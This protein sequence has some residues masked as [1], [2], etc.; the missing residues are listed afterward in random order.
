MPWSSKSERIQ[1]KL[2]MNNYSSVEE[3][4]PPV[5]SKSRDTRNCVV[6]QHGVVVWLNECG[7]WYTADCPYLVRCDV[8]YWKPLIGEHV[9]YSKAPYTSELFY[10]HAC[11]IFVFDDCQQRQQFKYL[12]HLLNGYGIPQGFGIATMLTHSDKE[13]TH[14]SDNEEHWQIIESDIYKLKELHLRGFKVAFPASGLGTTTSNMADHA[15]I[16][17]ARMN[18][19]LKDLFDY[20]PQS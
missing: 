1:V 13:T 19:L 20:A 5:S 7:T 4:L 14:L 15:P 17:F 18:A 12:R 6:D 8:Y 10:K 9:Y 2:Q 16:L 11:V 3:K